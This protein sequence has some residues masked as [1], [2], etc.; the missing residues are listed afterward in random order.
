MALFERSPPFTVPP[1]EFRRRAWGWFLTCRH[2]RVFSGE[3]FCLTDPQWHW[4]C[5]KCRTTG[6]KQFGPDGRPPAI[7]RDRF[8]SLEPWVDSLLHDWIDSADGRK[9]CSVCL[10]SD[11]DA[12]KLC[13][14]KAPPF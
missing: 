1:D 5:A 14:G 4:I 6:L 12:F 9:V 11:A 8:R 3:R 10:E 13:P 7:D 2:E